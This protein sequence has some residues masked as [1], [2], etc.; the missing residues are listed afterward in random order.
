LFFEIENPSIKE[1]RMA[2]KNENGRSFKVHAFNP[3]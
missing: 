1:I 2:L 3:E